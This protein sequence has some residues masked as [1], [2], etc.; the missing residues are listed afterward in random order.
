MV[1][2]FCTF[3][4]HRCKFLKYDVFL[5]MVVVSILATSTDQDE[6]LIYRELEALTVGIKSF[7]LTIGLVLWYFRETPK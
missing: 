5:I 2:H 6:M 7:E 3:R 1:A 4:G